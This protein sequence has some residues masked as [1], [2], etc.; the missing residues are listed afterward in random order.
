MTPE[1]LARW[2]VHEDLTPMVTTMPDSRV[3]IMV[4]GADVWWVGDWSHSQA[5]EWARW[6]GE[7]RAEA[8]GGE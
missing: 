7:V 5:L 8:G 3:V 6:M 4:W 1:N 2:L